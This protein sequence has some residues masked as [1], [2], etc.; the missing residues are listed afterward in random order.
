MQREPHIIASMRATTCSD[1]VNIWKS[2]VFLPHPEHRALGCGA[3]ASLAVHSVTS[4]AVC[5]SFFFMQRKFRVIQ[6]SAPSPPLRTFSHA[7]ARAQTSQPFSGP[8]T[9]TR[10]HARTRLQHD[11]TRHCE[12]NISHVFDISATRALLLNPHERV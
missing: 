5:L 9:Q 4:G 1:S 8:H 7:H 6:I 12:N 10:A 11:L 2:C 3:A